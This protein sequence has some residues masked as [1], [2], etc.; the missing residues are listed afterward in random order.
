MPSERK[1][2]RSLLNHPWLTSETT[3]FY[4]KEEEYF[5]LKKEYEMKKIINR[6]NKVI[7]KE[8]DFYCEDS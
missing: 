1:S 6:D 4:M 7:L 5:E 8:G 3:Q 2:A